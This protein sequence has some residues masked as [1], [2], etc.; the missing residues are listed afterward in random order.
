MSASSLRVWAC[1][2][3]VAVVL[4]SPMLCFAIS[5]QHAQPGEPHDTQA[6][7]SD[8]GVGLNAPPARITPTP[9]PERLSREVGGGPFNIV[10]L[11]PRARLLASPL[12]PDLARPDFDCSTC[13]SLCRFLV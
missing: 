1:C 10:P 5:R 3:V 9:K 7:L 11:A 8:G 4:Q 13:A 6:A 12:H 2:L